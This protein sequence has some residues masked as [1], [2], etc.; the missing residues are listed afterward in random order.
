M[1]GT[2]REA[3][4][5]TTAVPLGAPAFTVQVDQDGTEMEKLVGVNLSSSVSAALM[6][7]YLTHKDRGLDPGSVSQYIRREAVQAASGDLVPL[8]QMLAIQA[9]S[10]DMIFYDFAARAGNCTT[11]D[12]RE[13]CLK[14]ALKAQIQ[15]RT[16]VE[17]LAVIQ[18]GPAIFAKNANINHGQQQVNN[19]VPAP[20]GTTTVQAQEVTKP[21][22]KAPS[23][24]SIGT[25]FATSTRTRTRAGGR[26]ASLAKQTIGAERG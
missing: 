19:G 12:A 1:T 22:L 11:L 18:Q 25:T 10:L 14:I 17:S 20:A 26:N 3:R 24:P 16:T 21:S 8:Q 23:E 7:H 6:S 15:C 13:Q 9:K 4:P 5:K 2:A